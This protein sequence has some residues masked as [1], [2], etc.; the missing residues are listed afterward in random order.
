MVSFGFVISESEVF[1]FINNKEFGLPG[2]MW[3]LILSSMSAGVVGNTK[4]KTTILK[5]VLTAHL[6]LL[7]SCFSTR[8]NLL[9][10]VGKIIKFLS[11]YHTLSVWACITGIRYD[12]IVY[13]WRKCNLLWI[14]L[15]AFPD[16]RVFTNIRER[17]R[18]SS[19]L[20]K[21]ITE[22]IHLFVFVRVA[23][24]RTC[25]VRNAEENVQDKA[26]I[27]KKALSWPTRNEV[28]PIIRKKKKKNLG[29]VR[30][31]KDLVLV[32]CDLPLRQLHMSFLYEFTI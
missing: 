7:K 19:R 9:E 21:D 25:R 10:I 13:R 14:I 18:E 11:P 27:W 28:K 4:P 24:L 3:L 31:E 17:V 30:K 6:F 8:A 16:P 22:Q 1:R 2:V 23:I 26:N 32:E 20:P 5:P 12:I 29:E 15:F